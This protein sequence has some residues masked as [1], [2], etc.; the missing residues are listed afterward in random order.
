MPLPIDTYG[1]QTLREDD[2]PPGSGS[3]DNWHNWYDG[4]LGY[5]N[6]VIST[7]FLIENL[8]PVF[9]AKSDAHDTHNAID[10][11]GVK[12]CAILRGFAIMFSA[13]KP[14]PNE[15]FHAF[16]VRTGSPLGAASLKGTT[17][18]TNDANE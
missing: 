18:A 11:T 7:D 16:M 14:L 12:D 13:T 3:D 15:N 1:S 4:S 2:L 8:S 17:K 10:V 5:T 9:R 6:Q